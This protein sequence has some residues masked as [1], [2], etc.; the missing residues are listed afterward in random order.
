LY[1]D[2][3]AWYNCSTLKD[4]TQGRREPEK[5]EKG[6]EKGCHLEIERVFLRPYFILHPDSDTSLY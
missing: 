6:R 4:Q 2:E 3:Q 1:R 5:G